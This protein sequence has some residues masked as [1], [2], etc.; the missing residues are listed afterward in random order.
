[1]ASS[2]F[3]RYV[4]EDLEWLLFDQQGIVREQGLGSV[5]QFNDQLRARLDELASDPTVLVVPGEDVLMTQANVPSKQYRQIVQAVP[6][7]IEEQ[8]AMDLD[9]CFF[10]LGE[11]SDAGDI[12]VSVVQRTLLESWRDRAAELGLSITAVVSE[13]S[14]VASSDGTNVV[15]DGSRAHLH[16]RDAS[17]STGSTKDLSLL[18][19]LIDNPSPISI[20]VP[21]EDI[22]KIERIVS[23]LEASDETVT[24][25]K[26]DES[27]FEMLCRQYSGKQINLLQGDYKVDV[28]RSGL[29]VVWRSVAVLCGVAIL[30]HLL[31][32][33]GQG[34]YLSLKASEY[35]DS[36]K[37]LYQETFPKDRN[38][39]DLRRR[40]NSHLG[41]TDS[42]DH[43]FVPLFA[44]SS[45]GLLAAGLTL[46]NV[47]FN[48][49]RGDLILQVR[50]E[51]SEE[52]VAYAQE[53]SS[54]GLQAEIGTISQEEGSVRG[55]IKIRASGGSS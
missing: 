13:S 29:E 17:G 11:R 36:A 49:K 7:V 31:M 46:E 2:L 32:L 37:A 53:L 21:S 40:W 51:R 24:L 16:F 10:A 9:E 6:F 44:Q 48:E 25:V 43:V 12:A 39:R 30:L 28:R 22:E 20:E 55:S 5:D 4:D 47:N 33:T 27:A 34:W 14:L 23:E 54:S 52:L 41:N 50:G 45:Q 8:L 26:G 19:G 38:V 15:V 42:V 35:E 3:I 18:I 1:V